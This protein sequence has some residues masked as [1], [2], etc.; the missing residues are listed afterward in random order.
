MLMLLTLL[1]HS[2]ELTVVSEGKAPRE[3]RVLSLAPDATQRVRIDTELQTTMAMSGM[4]VPSMPMPTTFMVIETHTGTPTATHVPLSFEI[5]DVG[6]EGDG[7][8]KEAMLGEIGRVKGTRGDRLVAPHGAWTV[9]TEHIDDQVT[10]SMADGGPDLSRTLNNLS[11][12]LP[13]VPVGPG[14]SWRFAEDVVQGGLAISQVTTWTLEEVRRD[15]ILVLTSVVE[16]SAVAQTLETPGGKAELKSFATKGTG[17]T[18]VDPTRALPIE[19]T[20]TVD[21]DMAFE[22]MGMSAAQKVHM[23]ST[24]REVPR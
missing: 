1:A 23:T 4:D 15:G 3:V 19:A 21:T 24:Q 9:V 7:P 13:Q 20:H 2:G 5:V 17:R 18:V 12:L 16:Q 10:P 22:V 6:V 11:I 14:A 8:I